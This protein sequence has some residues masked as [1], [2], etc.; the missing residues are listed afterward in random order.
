ML[1]VVLGWT[2][3][4]RFVSI[5]SKLHYPV[6][7]REDLSES[8]GLRHA[9]E[10]IPWQGN[11]WISS[12]AHRARIF[13]N[14]ASRGWTTDLCHGGMVWNPR[15]SPYKNAITN[16]LWI[17]ASISMYLH[18]PGDNF[19]APWLASKG[20]PE[21]DPAHL[22]AAIEGYKWLM[23]V[24]MTNRQGL[25]V[26]GY[27]I[28]L[29]KPGNVECDIRDE[30]VYTYNQGVIL[31]GQRGLWTV[32]GAVS[33]LMDGHKLVQSVINATGWSLKHNSPVDDLA[34]LPSGQL[35]PWR[36]IGRGGILEEQCDAGGTCSQDAQTFKGIFFLH[37]TTFCKSL[38]PMHVEPG[39][40]VDVNAYEMVKAAHAE[41]CRSYVGWVRHN[42]LAALKTRDAQGRFGM[43][44]GAGLFRNTIVSKDN[45]GID[46]APENTTDYRNHG[47]PSN[48]VWGDN[49]R[50]LPG[51]GGRERAAIDDE[52]LFYSD[53][54]EKVLGGTRTGH[55]LGGI[56]TPAQPSKADSKDP[57]SRGRGRTVETQ[58]GG[59]ALLRAYWDMSRPI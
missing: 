48:N 23:G 21:K 46:D 30:M 27:H 11:N 40:T 7:L 26:D 17:S 47:T 3:T 18:F 6:N 43:W 10:T 38:G 14:L 5:H 44:W 13:W 34:H 2:E 55:D 24:N 32:S 28:N 25:F 4:I 54:E 49:W 19:T 42:A 37:L 31:T 57:N 41:A 59:L 33:Y 51:A 1:W 22:A 9:L 29:A 35:P 56:R 8:G 53:V 15:L 39:A 58:V 16:E 50:W 52:S 12:F 36:G 45:D 20:F